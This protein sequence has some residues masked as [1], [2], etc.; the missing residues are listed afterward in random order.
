[1]RIEHLLLTT[2]L[3]ASLAACTT[4]LTPN[5][6]IGVWGIGALPADAPAACANAST[7]YRSDGTVLI[8][9]GAET[10]TATYTITPMGKRLL[11]ERTNIQSN[12]EPNCQGRPAQYVVDHFVREAYLE[13]T[14][15]TLK[16]FR[17]ADAPSPLFV[18]VRTR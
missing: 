4:R 18:Y 16:V 1:V 13:L 15:D 17:S 6:L 8:R 2:L 7:E 10:V 11:V 12:G 5:K 3:G 9:S 14:P